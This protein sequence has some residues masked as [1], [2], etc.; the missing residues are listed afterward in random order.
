MTN[1]HI[2]D[3][4]EAC[5]VAA[6]SHY[7]ET[8]RKKGLN[9]MHH[10]HWCSADAIRNRGDIQHVPAAQPAVPAPVASAAGVLGY[11]NAGQVHELSQGRTPYAYVYPSTR[12]LVGATVTVYTAQQTAPAAPA[13]QPAKEQ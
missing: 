10:G 11:M 13:A 5:A 7:A 8:C 6:W 3:E 2:T 12:D 1:E 9:P 4:R